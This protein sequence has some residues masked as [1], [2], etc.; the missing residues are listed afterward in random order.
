MSLLNI[1]NILRKASRNDEAIESEILFG[2]AL[3]NARRFLQ[4]AEILRKVSDYFVSKS[5]LS[6]KFC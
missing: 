6:S 5:D 2:L 3:I 1:T 4:A